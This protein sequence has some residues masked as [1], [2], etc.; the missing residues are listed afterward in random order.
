MKLVNL[1]QPT[2][3]LIAIVGSV[4]V[5]CGQ[6]NKIQTKPNLSGTWMLDH[7]QSNMSE[8]GKRDAPIKMVHND[9]ELRMTRTFE[10][11]GQP[12]QREFVYFTDGRSET[13]SAT[14]LLTTQPDRLKPED[15]DKESVKSR[16]T[17]QR[18]KIV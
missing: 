18:D 12:V 17:W 2:A 16:T 11:N 10:R 7:N 15:I 6:A 4:I 8:I 13:K 14:T 5:I 1:A 3:I 9:P